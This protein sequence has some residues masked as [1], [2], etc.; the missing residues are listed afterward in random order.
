LVKVSFFDKD[1]ID[2]VVGDPLVA[3]A[4]SIDWTGF[5]FVVEDAVSTVCGIGI[6]ISLKG[7][8]VNCKGK[9]IKY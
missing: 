2:D 5:I 7:L 4:D 3:V 8:G 9:K 1:N 6:M